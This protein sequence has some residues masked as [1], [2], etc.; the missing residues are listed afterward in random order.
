MRKV[1]LF[2]VAILTITLCCVLSS[3]V[4]PVPFGN[5]AYYKRPYIPDNWWVMEAPECLC[6][7]MC[8]EEGWVP[9]LTIGGSLMEDRGVWVFGVSTH[10]EKGGILHF[11]E[12][13]DTQ[14]VEHCTGCTPILYEADV[15]YVRYYDD[16]YYVPQALPLT[17][18]P[19]GTYLVTSP[20][21]H[22]GN[23]VWIW[24][25]YDDGTGP[26]MDAHLETVDEFYEPP[27]STQVILYVT[28][29]FTGKRIQVDTITG[30]VVLPDETEEEMPPGMWTWNQEEE[31]YECSW[32]TIPMEGRY[33]IS[34]TAEKALYND[35]DASTTFE[36]CYGGCITLQFDRNPPVYEE[37]ETVHMTATAT[38]DGGNPV[39]GISGKVTREDHS[40]DLEWEE[41]SPG[42]YEAS[43]TPTVAGIYHVEIHPFDEYDVCYVPQT[44]EFEVKHRG[45][46]SCEIPEEEIDDLI[47]MYSPYMYFYGGIGEEEK[48]FPTP[49]ETMLENST[50]WR[51]EL[52][53]DSE[54][55]RVEILEFAQAADTSEKLEVLSI[56]P[57]PDHFLDLNHEH[58]G[59]D[60]SLINEQTSDRHVYCRVDCFGYERVEYIIIQY[61]FFYIF[62]DRYIDHEGDWEVA[63][64]LLDK[65]TKNPIG[66]CISRDDDAEY[67]LWEEIEKKGTH[68]AIYV[69][70][71]SHRE[72]FSEGSFGFLDVDETSDDG[73]KGVMS[74]ISTLTNQSWLWFRGNWGV[75]VGEPAESRFNT[76]NFGCWMWESGPYGPMCHEDIW[77]NPLEW[78]F[79]HYHNSPQT[80]ESPY[81]LFSLSCPVDM[82][83]VNSRGQRLG[84]VN[85]EFVQEIPNA[86]VQD[87]D[88]EEFYI[89]QGIDQYQVEV[90]GTGEGTLDLVC[91]TS[92]WNTTKTVK[93]RDVPVTVST[94]GVLD[95]RS[96]LSL[97]VDT[98]SDGTTDFTVLPVSVELSSQSPINPLRVGEEMIYELTLVNEGEPS[99]F[100]LEVDTP[101]TWS[102]ALSS[103]VISLNSGES[104]TILLRVTSPS[105]I[106]VQDYTVRVEATSFEDDDMTA[107]ISLTAS[108]RAEL[109]PE[110]I[111]VSPVRQ[112]EIAVTA[113]VSNKGLLSADSAK[114]QF[115][116]GSS[117]ERI[118]LGEQIVS[119]SPGETTPASIHCSLPDGFYTFLVSVDPDNSIDETSESNNE[120]SIQY[121]LDRTPPEAELFFDISSEDV[122]V[123]GVDNLSSTKIFI[124]EESS[125]NRKIRTYTL[126]DDAGNTTELAVEI[127]SVGRE[128][129]A[130]IVNLKYNSQP[131]SLPENQLKIEYLIEGSSIKRLNQF[132]LI[133]DT[134]IHLIYHRAKGYTQLTAKGTEDNKQGVLIVILQ[135]RKGIF[136]YAF[137]EI[138]M[139]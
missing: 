80:I 14:C 81:T 15:I 76:Y 4:S 133:G 11:R 84:I 110:E 20:S 102:H 77:N 53:G 111:T 123:R 118:F 32:H 92:L 47:Q 67:R 18:V 82:L 108:S 5:R 62:D 137:E 105:N 33:H 61:W 103:E 50:L 73:W 60:A 7:T 126:T 139:D 75:L 23:D 56:H 13:P 54:T 1:L 72:Y 100:I 49:V 41:V 37:N 86:C 12:Y 119:I 57:T 3:Q 43:Y 17:Y 117:S 34:V 94:R 64:V 65:Q 31:Q 71:G 10:E 42:V 134:R 45:R 58:C 122:K 130:E 116:A 35:A 114:I 46:F 24:Y 129:K 44:F 26:V 63:Q 104:A 36:V 27:T 25:F 39:S 51:Y 124:D 87:C 96:D 69:A 85:G 99:T 93:Y 128:I 90:A 28:D 48:F 52:A 40:D 109:T 59:I 106:P 8:R 74:G 89:I 136:Q 38:D 9:R 68:P 121:L 19:P 30:T 95:L 83:I 78:A 16:P 135:T 98:D 112:E 120:L 125:K 127:Q 29:Q 2:M 6:G 21:F 132:L 97:S 131:V 79:T 66:L 22:I 113:S 91:V 88:E 115:F 107:D 55:S 101:F 138:C 70:R